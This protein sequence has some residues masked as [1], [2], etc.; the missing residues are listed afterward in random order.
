MEKMGASLAHAAHCALPCSLSAENDEAWCARLWGSIVNVDGYDHVIIGGGSGGAALAARLSEDPL[1][2]VLLLEAGGW[3]WSPFIHIPGFLGNVVFNRTL[4]WMYEGEPDFSLGGRRLTWMAGRVLGGSSSINGMVYGRGLPDDYSRWVAAGNPGWGWDDMLPYFK[5][6][7]TWTGEP[8][9]ARGD[10][11]PLQVRKFDE[12][13]PACRSVMDAFVAAGLPP[14]DDYSAGYAEGIGIT[15]A[16]QHRGWRNSTAA[17]YLRPARRRPNLTIATHAR[18]L[19]LIVER[20]RCI[21]VVY[22]RKG[23]VQ[24]AHAAREVTVSTG[25][26]ATPKLLML[27][28]IGAGD[29]LRAHDLDVVHDLPG[30]GRHLN[31]HVNVKLSAAVDVRTY[32]TERFG[33]RKLI[34]G[35]RFL[36]DRTGPAASPANHCQGFVKSDPAL[37][38]AD[39]QVQVM[40]IAFNA[41]PTDRADGLSVV[42]SPCHPQVRGTVS[43]RTTDPM[44]PP[45]INIAMLSD[46]RDINVLLKGCRHARDMLEA[47]PGREFGARV[48]APA[49]KTEAEADWIAFFRETAAL[50]WHPTS[51]C[52]MGPGPDD[53]VDST[54]AVHGLAGLSIADASIMPCVT[55]ANTNVPV[56]AIAE[57]AADL[58][59]ARTN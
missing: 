16:T 21:G 40:P 26:I 11:G 41:D 33:L 5:R 8:S 13:H 9:L 31:D 17:A 46:A 55:S 6:L 10:G 23:R 48:F 29:D 57:K 52:R 3:D 1:R 28:G 58:I 2:R 43:L 56:I 18:A 36:Y 37:A 14:L 25:A 45:R 24:T 51:T 30:V 22:A 20:G 32:N 39:Y 34:N 47:G 49:S 4:N 27:S 19:K 38:S 42:V 44:A 54:L 59:V 35:A 15:Q 12:I 53:V 50:N 7:E